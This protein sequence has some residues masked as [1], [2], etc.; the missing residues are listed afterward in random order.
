VAWLRVLHVPV[1]LTTVLTGV[2]EPLSY[3]ILVQAFLLNIATLGSS[4]NGGS[5]QKFSGLL[6]RR[7][8]K[9][10]TQVVQNLARLRLQYLRAPATRTQ[11]KLPWKA[12]IKAPLNESTGLAAIPCYPVFGR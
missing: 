2:E 5:A 9:W 4:F 3:R 6:R 12:L 10:L 7:S 1:H 11:A 8:H